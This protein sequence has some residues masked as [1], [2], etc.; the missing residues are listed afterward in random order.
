MYEYI[1]EVM[2]FKECKELLKVGKNT[3]LDLIH[4]GQIQAFKVGNRWKIRKQAVIEFIQYK[5]LII[6]NI[7]NIISHNWKGDIDLLNIV[8]LGLA[9]DLPE[10]AEKYELQQENQRIWSEYLGQIFHQHLCY[11]ETELCQLWR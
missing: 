10:K 3:L 2:T 9:E 1:P 4:T 7:G 6:K 11:H 8:L 5:W